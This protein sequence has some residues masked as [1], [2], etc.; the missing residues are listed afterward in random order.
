[1]GKKMK[2][3]SSEKLLH[4]EKLAPNDS[5]GKEIVFTNIKR[6]KIRS[7]RIFTFH[8]WKCGTLMHIDLSDKPET[9]KCWQCGTVLTVPEE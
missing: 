3:T 2:T 4:S 8:C 1:M 6:G 5:S 7:K 9:L